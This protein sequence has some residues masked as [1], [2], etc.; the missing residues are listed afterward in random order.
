M[1]SP[2][3][4]R[5][6]YKFWNKNEKVFFISELVEIDHS[7]TAPFITSGLGLGYMNAK[8]LTVNESLEILRNKRL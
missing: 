8:P 1:K 4:N 6:F 5:W 3:K 7:K 2:P